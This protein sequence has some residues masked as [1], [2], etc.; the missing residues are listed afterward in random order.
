[1]MRRTLTIDPTVKMRRTTIEI[2]RRVKKESDSGEQILQDLMRY[3]SDVIHSASGA[4][5][6]TITIRAIPAWKIRWTNGI[7]RIHLMS[8]TIPAKIVGDNLV[9]IDRAMAL[10]C[11]R[12]FDVF[13]CLIFSLNLAQFRLGSAQNLGS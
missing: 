1:M 6:K 4:I 8:N 3:P 10:H 12:N 13:V 11:A 5:P 2:D 7:D 9:Q